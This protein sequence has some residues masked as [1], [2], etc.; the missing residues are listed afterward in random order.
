[1]RILPYHGIRFQHIEKLSRHIPATLI[2]PESALEVIAGIQ[3]DWIAVFARFQQVFDNS[4]GTCIAT[5]ALFTLFT[6]R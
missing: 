2:V 1:M 5:D 4:Y 3:V 6:A